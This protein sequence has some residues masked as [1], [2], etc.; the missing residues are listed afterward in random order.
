MDEKDRDIW[1]KHTDHA[2]RSR[3]TNNVT[4]TQ[5]YESPEDF[6]GGLLADDMGLGKTL[7]MIC[8]IAANQAQT[9]LPSPPITPEP[10]GRGPI[11]ELKTTLLIVPPSLMQSW[12]KQLDM[13]IRPHTLKWHIFHGSK[14]NR[15]DYL[16]QFDIVIT[17]FHTVSAIWRKQNGNFQ[18]MDS[19][20]SVLWHRVI[21]DE[22]HLIQNP[23]S[24]LTQACYA[25]R[26]PRR[27]AITGTP[28][29]NKLTDFASIVKFLKVYPYSEPGRFE[30]DI[31][32][33]WHCGDQQ[34]FLR[35]KKLVGAITISRTKAVVELP[36]RINEIHH[37]DFSPAERIKYDIAEA[38]VKPYTD[39]TLPPPSRPGSV[40]N[41]LQQLNNLRLICS[42]G[43]LAQ[44]IHERQSI[45]ALTG[46][47]SVS[48]SIVQLAAHEA[49]ERGESTGV[50]TTCS[51]CCSDILLDPDVPSC[52]F[53]VGKETICSQCITQLDDVG[54]GQL[55]WNQ[56]ESFEPLGTTACSPL[57]SPNS[58]IT[59]SDPIDSM[60]TKIKAL[61]VD[62]LKH[63]DTT[64]R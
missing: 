61:I 2:G 6:Q 10:F 63:I 59:S 14:R 33:P 57:L 15:L 24:Q 17:T 16:G 19:I 55:S 32:K 1:A 13:H 53:S 38:Q 51:Q 37:L 46:L 56:M 47:T 18:S 4:G 62:L 43:L 25:V 58:D 11:P 48:D 7:S 35:L 30:E 20:F 36:L 28:I 40:F 34:G 52:N 29:Q 45:Q 5:Q 64:K 8:L 3:F 44:S 54:G 21:L 39:N 9:A 60:S 12:E 41:K 27:W 23:Q 31:Y 26:S 50:S 22:A 42:H 49:L